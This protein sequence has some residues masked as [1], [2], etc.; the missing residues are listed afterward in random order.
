MTQE[1]VFISRRRLWRAG[2]KIMRCDQLAAIGRRNLGER[3]R[4][5]VRALPQMATDDAR[6]DFAESLAGRIVV[7]LKGTGA[8]LGENG[9]LMLRAASRGLAID[10]VDGHAGECF[11]P[12]ADLHIAASHAGEAILR[13]VLARKGSVD[14]R[15]GVAYLT[16]HHDPRL[17]GMALRRQ[18]TLRAAYLGHARNVHIPREI[19][20]RIHRI[21]LGRGVD[22]PAAFDKL[23]DFNLHFALRP[24]ETA[25][26]RDGDVAKPFT[27]G[28]VAAALGANVMVER[29]ADDA[30]FY[31]GREYP[32][33]V[34]DC[35]PE[36]IVAA[37]DRADSLYDTSAWHEASERM[38]YLRDM[39]SP[40]HVARE[41]DVILSRLQVRDGAAR[42][43]RPRP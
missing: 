19:S 4:F 13:R 8:M 40:R 38:R 14:G 17:E 28:F 11:S 16:H 21:A 12:H 36:T 41:L 3:Y 25:G 9:M 20:H 15:A 27:K 26:T 2:S 23:C 34:D 42:K 7:L 6:R 37:L 24:P 43:D 5:S 32:F 18:D 35:A 10:Y 33:L 39:S 1:V 22:M 29:D 30:G 31:L